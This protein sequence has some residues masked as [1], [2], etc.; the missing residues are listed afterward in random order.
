MR[1]G[2]LGGVFGFAPGLCEVRVIGYPVVLSHT[3]LAQG[4]L[5]PKCEK[6]P[7]YSIGA[8]GHGG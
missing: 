6:P 4:L 2:L 3:H 8:C 7:H 1:S 5:P